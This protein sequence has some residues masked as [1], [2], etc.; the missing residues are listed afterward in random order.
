M[1]LPAGVLRNMKD[2][3]FH[4]IIFRMAPMPGAADVELMAQ[5][6]KSMGHH[7]Q[8]FASMDEVSAYFAD[9]EVIAKGIKDTG[10]KWDWDGEEVP[11]MVEFFSPEEYLG[12]DS[13]MQTAPGLAPR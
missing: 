8:G 4:P 13:G 6:F 1:T 5:R 11:A 12:P 7:T 3:R 9:P 10:R 2:G